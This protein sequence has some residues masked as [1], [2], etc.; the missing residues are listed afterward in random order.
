MTLIQMH[1]KVENDEVKP[2]TGNV[3]PRSKS[4]ALE[5]SIVKYE[6]LLRWAKRHM[7][8]SMPTASGN[9]CSLCY[10]FVERQNNVLS[11]CVGCP[12]SVAT[13]FP[14]CEGSPWEILENNYFG[15]P[16]TESTLHAIAAEI[17]FLKSLRE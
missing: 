15:K 6:W 11:L 5:H 10:M 1:M 3:W 12:V 17:E 14:D 13:G 4:G 9:S 16:I 8:D 7:G 2:D